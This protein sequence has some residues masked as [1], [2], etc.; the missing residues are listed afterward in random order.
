M[1]NALP[2]TGAAAAIALITPPV[3]TTHRPQWLPWFLESYVNGV[4]NLGVTASLALP[5]VSL[6]GIRVCRAGVWLSA[7]FAVGAR[8]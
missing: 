3:W 1:V 4:H 7:I 5:V 8:A 6:G 2:A